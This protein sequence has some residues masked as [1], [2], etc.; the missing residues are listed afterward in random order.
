MRALSVFG[1]ALMAGCASSGQ[2]AKDKIASVY[3][4]DFT[5]DEPESCRALDIPLE[6]GEAAAFFQRAKIL[7]Y[8]TLSDNYPVAPC[9]IVGTLQ[10]DDE[11]CRFE[12]SAA[13][14]GSIT[15]KGKETYFACDTCKDLFGTE[16]PVQPPCACD[17]GAR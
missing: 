13:A 6:H 4:K 11:N 7:D 3:V 15:C 16:C 9:R 1:L 12:I 8:H 5:S 10:Y 17:D 14:T 2:F